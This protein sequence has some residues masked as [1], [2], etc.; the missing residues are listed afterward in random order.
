M[1]KLSDVQIKQWIKAGERFDMRSDGD[2]LYL[3]FRKDYSIPVWRFRY[4][5]AGKQR[6]MNMGSYSDLSL[7]DARKLA[8]EL[9]AKVSLGHDVAAEKQERKAEAAAKIEAEKNSV[10]VGKLAD[11]YFE[12]MILGRWK[13]PNI[14]RSRIERDIKPSIGKMK[15][16]DVK[17]VHIDAMLQKIVKRGAPTIANDVLRW[18]RRMFDFA[19]KRYMVQYNPASAFD[20]SDA[21]GREEARDRALSREELVMLFEAMRDAKGFSHE[22]MLTVKLL[23]LLAVRKQELT[24]ARQTEFD[25]DNAVWHLPAERVKTETA[26]D[27]PLPP[28]AVEALRELQQ[29]ACGSEWLLPAR[30]AQHRM[31]PHIHENTLNVAMAKLKPLMPGVSPFCIHDF[32]RT[33]RTHLAALGIDPHIAERCLN[34]KIK[35]IEGIYNRH[36]YF[37]ERRRAL[38]LWAKFLDACEKGSDWNV[39]PLRRPA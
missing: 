33:A 30:K 18:T 20:L 27:I 4:R 17:P 29:L 37:D 12:R 15:V 11:E 7:A 10:T 39:I 1:G 34:H 13:H 38:E 28:A 35:G 22:N 8:K 23:L 24:G 16:E 14:V 9:R 21:G 31:I 36:D 2:G 32:R 5:F 25:L 3:S 26:I 19:V 6:V